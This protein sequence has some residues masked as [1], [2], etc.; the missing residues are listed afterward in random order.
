[1]AKAP[2]TASSFDGSGA[3]WFKV[4]QISAVTDGGKS[5]KFPTDSEG[6]RLLAFA[7]YY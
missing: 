5:I 1:M 2:S 6:E 4:A 3:V 7:V